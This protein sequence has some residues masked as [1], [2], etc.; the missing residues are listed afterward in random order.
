MDLLDENI[1]EINRKNIL[2]DIGEIN[3]KMYKNMKI[4]SKCGFGISI[5]TH[6]PWNKIYVKYK[7]S[8]VKEKSIYNFKNMKV[9]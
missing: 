4:L 9:T 2:I 3:V 7:N 1:N 5:Q 8:A 6:R